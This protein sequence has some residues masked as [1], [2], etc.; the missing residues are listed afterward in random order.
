MKIESETI[1]RQYIAKDRVELYLEEI[2]TANKKFNLFSRNLDR[3]A[4]R[5][6]V[7]ESLLPLE[8]GWVGVGAGAILDIG[9]GWGIP[10]LPLL[11]TG[12]EFEITLVE[13]SQ[14]KADFLLLLL[15]RLGL[16]AVI[17]NEELSKLP[18]S[19]KYASVLVR[20]V[21]IDDKILRSIKRLADENASLIYFG[22]DFQLSSFESPQIV[23]YSIDGGDPRCI[24]K[25]GIS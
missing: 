11:M 17:V 1:L 7:A 15:H 21:G 24:I 8:M 13:R 4:L 20:Q 23:D 5:T 18:D 9:S 10:S 25:A 3:G 16:K 12:R 14:K 2:L 22:K 6:L 19:E